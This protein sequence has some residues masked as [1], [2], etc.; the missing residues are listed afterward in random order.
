M[1]ELKP[2]ADLGTSQLAF[3]IG[4]KQDNNSL[5]PKSTLIEQS[6]WPRRAK[7]PW[8]GGFSLLFGTPHVVRDL[9][10][11]QPSYD[12]LPTWRFVTD[13]YLD[14]DA[15][16]V[17]LTEPMG[18]EPVRTLL[19]P[20][21]GFPGPYTV[22]PVYERFGINTPYA[23]VMVIARRPAPPPSAESFRLHKGGLQHPADIARKLQPLAKRALRI[24]VQSDSLL[25]DCPPNATDIFGEPPNRRYPGGPSAMSPGCWEPWDE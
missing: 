17:M 1:T 14:D 21:I 11:L 13:E 7:G 9:A 2:P 19:L 4:N 22:L 23:E 25:F 15:S 10:R 16:A 20:Q 6:R 18:V 8:S 3:P 5:R 12:F 24:F